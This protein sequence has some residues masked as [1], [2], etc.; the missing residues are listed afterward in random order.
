MRRVG[1]QLLLRL[2]A[3]MLLERR[4]QVR[5]RASP[6]SQTTNSTLSYSDCDH[7]H[8]DAGIVTHHIAVTWELENS[9]TAVDSSVAA[10][11]WDYTRDTSQADDGSDY[12]TSNIF[13]DDWFGPIESSDHPEHHI[14]NQ[15]IFAYTR[16]KSKGNG[17][18]SITNPYGLLR[19]PWNTNPT[20]YVMRHKAVFGRHGARLGRSPPSSA[21]CRCLLDSA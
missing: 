2:Y 6:I 5:L 19:S 7:W 18:T 4:L 1:L 15:G 12:V 3:D 9:L 13:N 20:P 21:L 17:T 10:H 16:I 8:D 14:V 11:Y